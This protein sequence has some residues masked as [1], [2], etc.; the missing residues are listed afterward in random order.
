MV[1]EHGIAFERDQSSRSPVAKTRLGTRVYSGFLLSLQFC[2]HWPRGSS[3]W[4]ALR[5]VVPHIVERDG[6]TEAAAIRL[7]CRYIPELWVQANES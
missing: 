1:R 3:D 7:S 5:M 2:M 6:H 4:N